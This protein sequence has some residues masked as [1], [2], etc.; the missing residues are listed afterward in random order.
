MARR[1]RSSSQ[2]GFG[3]KVPCRRA[4]PDR[5]SRLPNSIGDSLLLAT[6]CG[7]PRPGAATTI[8]L[9]LPR[10]EL[11]PP[12]AGLGATRA[13]TREFHHLSNFGPHL[14]LTPPKDPVPR[15]HPRGGPAFSIQLIQPLNPI[16]FSETD[17]RSRRE[18][19]LAR[20][21]KPS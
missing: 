7:S 14:A 2:S 15:H 11:D 19:A 5:L 1:V 18:R 6:R 20:A 13:P 12:S 10:A 16:A 17:G 21:P 9:S 3:R 8:A 4:T